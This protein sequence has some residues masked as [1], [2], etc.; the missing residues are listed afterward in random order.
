M[1]WT[2][3]NMETGDLNRFY[4]VH[5]INRKAINI[6][7]FYPEHSNG[8]CPRLF[9]FNYAVFKRIAPDV[10]SSCSGSDHWDNRHYFPGMQTN[11]DWQSYWRLD[12]NTINL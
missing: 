6:P 5:S 4:K 8:L 1:Q 2:N 12:K 7:E 11:Y 9:G 3:I 10:S